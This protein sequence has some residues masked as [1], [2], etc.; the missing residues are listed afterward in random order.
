MKWRYKKVFVI[1]H[2]EWQSGQLKGGFFKKFSSGKISIENFYG[3]LCGNLRETLSKDCVGV[4][5]CF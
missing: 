5:K 4:G 3:K 1:G 2:C